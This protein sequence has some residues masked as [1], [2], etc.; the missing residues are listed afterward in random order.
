MTDQKNMRT[1]GLILAAGESSRFGGLKQLAPVDGEPLLARIVHAAL[2]SGLARTIVVLGCGAERIR[3]ELGGILDHPALS[4]VTNTDYR[5]GMATSV[6]A[7]MAQVDSSFDSAMIILGDFPLLNARIIDM[8]L[9]AYRIS[10][11]GICL[12]V[13]D[14]RWGH[15][16]CLSRR[17]FDSLRQI[18]GD[19]GAR[20]IVRGSWSDVYPFPIP[21]NGCFFDVDTQE[22]IEHLEKDYRLDKHSEDSL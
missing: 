5:A 11:R 13:R 19:I 16:I 21:E 17:Y 15:P 8:V 3:R 6:R 22:D 18:E 14:K 1:A 4:V 9:Q 2:A 12:P 7:G 20:E 10:G